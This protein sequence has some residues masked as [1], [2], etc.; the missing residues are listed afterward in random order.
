V[1]GQLLRTG[2]R[3][4]HLV[5]G[6]QPGAPGGIRFTP[7]QLFQHQTVQGLAAVASLDGM[8]CK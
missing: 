1:R 6:G 5:A 7:K 4:D 2:R 3:L 8:A